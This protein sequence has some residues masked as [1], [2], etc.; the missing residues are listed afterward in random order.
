MLDCFNTDTFNPN[1]QIEM[2]IGVEL[3]ILCWN[4]GVMCW[5]Y[6]ALEVMMARC[7]KVVWV[8]EEDRKKRRGQ[9]VRFD[10]IL[11]SPMEKMIYKCVH[12]CAPF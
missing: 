8:Q 2:V 7:Y 10:K 1:K 4:G 5:S 12:A 3:I 9:K 6:I 11:N